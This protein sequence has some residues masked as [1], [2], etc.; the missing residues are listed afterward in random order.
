MQYPGQR[1]QIDVKYVPTNC[2]CRELQE[3]EEKFNSNKKTMFELK[4]E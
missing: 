4:L 3:M 1:I 2:L